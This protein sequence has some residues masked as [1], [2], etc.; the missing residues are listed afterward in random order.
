MEI[1]KEVSLMLTSLSLIIYASLTPPTLAEW[2]QC[3][4]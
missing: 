4:L 2:K 1:A 3:R